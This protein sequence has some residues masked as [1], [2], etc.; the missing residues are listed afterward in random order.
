ML[1]GIVVLTILAIEPNAS[2]KADPASKYLT[3]V[4]LPND[5]QN[6]LAG[7]CAIAKVLAVRAADVVGNPRFI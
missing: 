5:P 3:A 6:R 4:L 1:V 7:I 2:M